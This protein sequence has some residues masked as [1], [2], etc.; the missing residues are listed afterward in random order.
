[1]F[2]A[3]QIRTTCEHHKHHQ[4]FPSFPHSNKGSIIV[5]L[6]SVG[7][8]VVTKSTGENNGMGIS[9]MS[10]TGVYLFATLFRV[11][12]AG[13]NCTKQKQFHS[14][15]HPV[16]LFS[17]YVF[18]CAAAN[19][20][21]KNPVFDSAGRYFHINFVL[22]E[23]RWSVFALPANR[24]AIIPSD[25]MHFVVSAASRIVVHPFETNSNSAET[26]TSSLVTIQSVTL[27]PLPGERPLLRL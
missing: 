18:S 1:M 6:N 2:T 5:V 23:Q 21:N 15:G 3:L 27:Q 14:P 20:V 24:R 26:P 4:E 7:M 19:P 13:G 8:P 16:A 9:L 25:F 11:W 22:S 10:S 12:Q 17:M